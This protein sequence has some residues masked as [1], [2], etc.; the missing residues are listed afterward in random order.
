[1]IP[2]TMTGETRIVGAAQ[3]EYQP[4]SIRDM[5]ATLHKADGDV[6]VN[7]MVTAWKPTAEELE[8][9]NAGEPVLLSILGNV[10][11]PA[12]IWVAGE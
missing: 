1:M 12:N 10:W 2:Q 9:L 11:P 4:L 8:R 3:P 7:A 5:P 6:T